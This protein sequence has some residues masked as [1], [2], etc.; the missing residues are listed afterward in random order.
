[1]F[2]PHFKEGKKLSEQG[3]LDLPLPDDDG[4]TMETICHALHLRHSKLSRHLKVDKLRNVAV[5]AD[6]YKCTMAL[7]PI[8]EH[9]L[10]ELKKFCSNE[11]RANLICCSYLL[12]LPLMFRE[13]GREHI[14]R[15][16][17]R[18]TAD[19][20]GPGR[21]VVQMVLSKSFLSAEPAC[22]QS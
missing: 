17:I 11:T 10:R 6:K 16:N 5:L 19:I 4:E 22:P 12:R 8:A 7:G 14:L 2:G 1:M 9:W 21:K 3:T 20:D 13:L 18:C 15:C